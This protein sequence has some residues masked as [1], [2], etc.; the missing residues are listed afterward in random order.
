MQDELKKAQ[1]DAEKELRLLISSFI[2][3]NRLHRFV[4]KAEGDLIAHVP[5][6]E[7]KEEINKIWRMLRGGIFG[8]EERVERKIARAESELEEE[9]KKATPRMT[10]EDIE[11]LGDLMHK[12]E[13]FNAWLEKFGSRGGE[14][15]KALEASAEDPQNKEKLEHVEELILQAIKA[16]ENLQLIVKR[17]IETFKESERNWDDRK[18]FLRPLA[19]VVSK[20]KERVDR[21]PEI[22]SSRDFSWE[23]RRQRSEEVFND[24]KKL[25]RYVHEFFYLNEKFGIYK[26]INNLIEEGSY[27][28]E[29]ISRLIWELYQINDRIGNASL[30]Y[31]YS[32]EEV[33]KLA[34][35]FVSKFEKVRESIARLIE[36]VN[37]LK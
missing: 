36:E 35:D 32:D 8:S 10:K 37:K 24:L 25:T 4:K 22:M 27:I 17:V 6:E 11:K 14:I 3:L 33:T 9:A 18:I 19:R 21:L 31:N 15:E 13:V 28:E 29:D 2:A 16:D 12:T 5:P 34:E 30:S 1:N 20:T 26:R 23:D 7:E